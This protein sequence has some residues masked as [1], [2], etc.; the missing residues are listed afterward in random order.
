MNLIVRYP[1]R[2]EKFGGVIEPRHGMERELRE[3]FKAG[4]LICGGVFVN[5]RAVESVEIER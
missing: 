3:S 4:Y 2:V 1:N 5:L